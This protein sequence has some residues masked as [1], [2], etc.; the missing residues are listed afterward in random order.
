MLLMKEDLHFYPRN[1]FHLEYILIVRGSHLN[2]KHF[3]IFN[4][5]VYNLNNIDAP[6]L[7]MKEGHIALHTSVGRSVGLYV[8]IP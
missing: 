8:G 1:S 4:Y 3:Y 2:C 7:C 6:P 5:P